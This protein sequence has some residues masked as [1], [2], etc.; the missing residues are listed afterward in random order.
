M[1]LRKKHLYCFML[2]ALASSNGY[3]THAV[4]A[5]ASTADRAPVCRVSSE[6]APAPEV[7]GDLLAVSG[8]YFHPGHAG[9]FDAYGAGTHQDLP[10]ANTQFPWFDVDDLATPFSPPRG[11]RVL[12]SVGSRYIVM[13]RKAGPCCSDEVGLLS[14]GQAKPRWLGKD[15]FHLSAV[16]TRSGELWVIGSG[17][18]NGAADKPTARLFR[19]PLDGKIQ[20]Y[21]FEFVEQL[22]AAQLALTADDRVAVL[23]PRREGGKLQLLLSWLGTPPGTVLL[24]EVITSPA[25]AELSHRSL[26]AIAVAPDAGRGLGVAWRPLVESNSTGSWTQPAAAEVRWLT[27]DAD[28]QT[29]APHRQST[30]AEALAFTTGTGP[31]GLAGNG[32]KASVLGGRAF[33]AWFDGTKL[34]GTRAP[35]AVPA[36]LAASV[37]GNSLI[38]LRPRADELELLLLD[39]FP[40]VAA[41]RVRCR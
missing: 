6:P 12:S 10:H 3:P 23:Y 35:D 26:L 22:Y 5:D 32:L 27:V 29:S 9:G 37:S 41:W 30:T 4:A 2:A 28:G 24:D 40:R 36:V 33:F 15:F 39:S 38:A 19:I 7:H 11:V 16:E 31:Y 34:V 13:R 20:Q 25:V 1:W 14:K 21:P 18:D 8:Q 17:T